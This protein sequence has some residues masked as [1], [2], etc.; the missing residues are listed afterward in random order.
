MIPFRIPAVL[1]DQ[2]WL[3]KLKKSGGLKCYSPARKGY[4]YWHTI[5]L[6][7]FQQNNSHRKL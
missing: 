3:D 7:R 1:K 2:A 5:F 4:V 6:E